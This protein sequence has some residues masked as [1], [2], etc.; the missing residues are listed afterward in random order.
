MNTLSVSEVE[1]VFDLFV[2]PL[3]PLSALLL[4]TTFDYWISIPHDREVCFVI[5]NFLGRM[6]EVIYWD[7]DVPCCYFINYYANR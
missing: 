1:M 5:F 7:A 6:W 4:F 3:L 2:M